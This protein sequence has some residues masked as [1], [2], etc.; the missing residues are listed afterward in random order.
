MRGAAVSLEA[1][2]KHWAWHNA[3]IKGWRGKPHIT[4]LFILKLKWVLRP[5]RLWKW[6]DHELLIISPQTYKSPAFSLFF[7]SHTGPFWI[8]SDDK[9]WVQRQLSCSK[10]AI[11]IEDWGWSCC[12][13]YEGNTGSVDRWANIKWML[14]HLWL[15]I[16]KENQEHNR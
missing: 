1:M 6:I 16:K 12:T 2:L 7:H 15:M 9:T 3:V 5:W 14:E 13:V 10:W 8:C 4:L 11:I